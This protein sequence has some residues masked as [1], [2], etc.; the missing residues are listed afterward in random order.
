[1]YGYVRDELAAGRGEELEAALRAL[2]RAAGLCFAATFHETAG[3]EDTAL[4]ELIR[5]MGRA[6]AQ[7]V[8][9]PSLDHLAGQQ[10]P[11]EWLLTELPG[12]ATARLWTLSMASCEKQCVS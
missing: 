3:S 2:A 6:E 10:I 7:H 12:A 8:A 9:V 5:E 11:P 4:W 1:M